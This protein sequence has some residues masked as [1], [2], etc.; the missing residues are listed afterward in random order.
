MVIASLRR[1]GDTIT[2]LD[3]RLTALEK[4]TPTF[5]DMILSNALGFTD[6]RLPART[7]A[8]ISLERPKA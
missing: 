4:P 3:T 5:E 6:P 8:I 7:I 1:S 2:W